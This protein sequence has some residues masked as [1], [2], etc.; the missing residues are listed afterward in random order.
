MAEIIFYCDGTLDKFVGD[1]IMAIWGAPADQPDHA[2]RALRCAF[3]MSDKLERLQEKWR[4][5][6]RHNIDCGIGINSGEVVIGNIG[7]QGKKMDYTAIGSH[8][9]LA[10]RVEKLNRKYESR[11]LITGNTYE[12]IKPLLE[13]KSIGHGDFRELEPVQVRGME[14]EARIFL[15]KSLKSDGEPPMA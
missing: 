2:E 11:I 3:H 13:R 8:V 1:E 5:E 9:N 12:A 7:I 4:A 15:V 6:G 10:A 14:E